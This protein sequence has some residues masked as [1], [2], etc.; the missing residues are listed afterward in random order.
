MSLHWFFMRRHPYTIC[1]WSSTAYSMSFDKP[2][3]WG[4]R[5]KFRDI[6]P[7][8]NPVQRRSSLFITAEGEINFENDMK[9]IEYGDGGDND[10]GKW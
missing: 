5:G 7:P 4:E 3:L 8:S 10:E 1:I 2:F 6:R 9:Q